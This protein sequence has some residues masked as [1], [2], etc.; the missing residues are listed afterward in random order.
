MLRTEL[1]S[2]E[3]LILIFNLYHLAHICLSTIRLKHVKVESK[4]IWKIGD[5]M[6]NNISICN[7]K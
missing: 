4:N 7:M 3:I 2:I 1:L 6:E 5:H